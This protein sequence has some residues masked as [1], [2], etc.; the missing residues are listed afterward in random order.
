MQELAD[1]M[2]E[3]EQ[4][5]ECSVCMDAGGLSLPLSPPFPPPPTPLCARWGTGGR[6]RGEEMLILTSL[7]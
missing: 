2:L 7:T 3:D 5:M 6:G 1:K 4:A